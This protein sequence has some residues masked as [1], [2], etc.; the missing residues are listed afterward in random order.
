MYKL[1]PPCNTYGW[2]EVSV[3][4]EIQVKRITNNLYSAELSWSCASQAGEFII[5]N[6]LKRVMLEPDGKKPV[7]KL[8]DRLDL[9]DRILRAYRYGSF[10][11][12]VIRFL[13]SGN[14]SIL[15]LE[16]RPDQLP[17]RVLCT[18]R[19]ADMLEEIT[20]GKELRKKELQKCITRFFRLLE[21]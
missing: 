4:G 11:R 19:M 3:D 1:L 10:G 7:F 21:A 16:K 12:S 2:A 6:G 20:G 8:R 15:P 9:R 14:Y 13:A 17:D 18:M 5:V